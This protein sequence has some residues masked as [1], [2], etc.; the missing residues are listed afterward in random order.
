M[1]LSSK[2]LAERGLMG[3]VPVKTKTECVEHKSIPHYSAVGNMEERK[4][5]YPLLSSL[6][7]RKQLMSN[8]RNNF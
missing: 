3:R 4:R 1:L 8:M 7:A 6:P 5:R 2:E